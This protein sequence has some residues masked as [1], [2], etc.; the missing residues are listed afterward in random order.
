MVALSC[1]ARVGD[2]DDDCAG[3]GSG[4]GCASGCGDGG[5]TTGSSA[6]NGGDACRCTGTSSDNDAVG[7]GDLCLRTGTGFDS[8]AARGLD[9][10]VAA[11]DGS[12]RSP[13]LGGDGSRSDLPLVGDRD[14]FLG[15]LKGPTPCAAGV[16]ILWR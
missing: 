15:S 12:G 13:F 2:D 16:Q 8:G 6:D 11:N 10:T 3:K 14:L 1:G 9:V 5:L 7:E 4:K